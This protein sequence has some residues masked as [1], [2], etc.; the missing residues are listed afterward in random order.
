MTFSIYLDEKLTKRLNRVAAESG[1]AR[2]ALIREALEQWLAKSQPEAWPELVLA[3]K[4]VRGAPSFEK[5]RK[6]LTPPREP[7]APFKRTAG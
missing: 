3:F 2:N 1:R 6:T 7:F 5:T 4:G